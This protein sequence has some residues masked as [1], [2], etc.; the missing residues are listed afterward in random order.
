MCGELGRHNKGIPCEGSAR[1]PFIVHAPGHIKPGTVI[2]QA[3]GTVDFKPTLLGL[4]GV[5][6]KEPCEGRDA[7]GLLRSGKA[8]AGWKDIAFVR[9]GG[10]KPGGKSWLG[11]F[12]PRHKLVIS[13]GDPPGFFDLEKDPTELRNAFADPGYREEIRRL[14][15]ELEAYGKLHKDP[16][17]KSTAVRA[18]LQ[19]AASGTGP[20]KSPPRTRS[21]TQDRGKK[22]KANP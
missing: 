7:S 2:H 10:G 1:I 11:A 9:I 14:A 6:F 21:T 12:T 3:L 16:L 15:G 8:P 5:N 19:W 18:D 4:L 22:V 17:M 20:Y 13:P